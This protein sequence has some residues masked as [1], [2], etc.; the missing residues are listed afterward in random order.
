MGCSLSYFWINSQKGLQT[1][2]QFLLDRA[3]QNRSIK[4]PCT[5]AFLRSATYT[6]T[7]E[8]KELILVD[9]SFC[10]STVKHVFRASS[11]RR[12]LRQ[13]RIMHNIL[14]M[15]IQKLQALIHFELSSIVDHAFIVSTN[16]Q[17]K[18]R[19]QADNLGW[20]I[21]YFAELYGFSCLDTGFIWMHG[22]MRQMCQDG[23]NTFNCT[24]K[25]CSIFVMKNVE[26]YWII[27]IRHDHPAVSLCSSTTRRLTW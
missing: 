10:M 1:E 16:V 14:D 18:C 3:V 8:K 6:P 19:I 5:K 27:S 2:F 23:R 15:C 13:K 21:L 26:E 22:K 4:M 9:E 20:C 11:G 12:I 7:L 25:F 24:R 17:S